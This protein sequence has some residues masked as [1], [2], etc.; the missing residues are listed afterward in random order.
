M[1][2]EI[3]DGGGWAI[4]RDGFLIAKVIRVIDHQGSR[5]GCRK[6]ARGKCPSQ[7]LRKLEL[8]SRHLFRMVNHVLCMASVAVSSL[9]SSVQ[10]FD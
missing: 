4:A 9:D 5:G 2:E 1:G 7:G 3:P 6:T 10:P 8:M